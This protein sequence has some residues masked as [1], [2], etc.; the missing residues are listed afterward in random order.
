MPVRIARKER[1]KGTLTLES[2]NTE[3]DIINLEDQS[4]DYIIEGQIDLSNMAEGDEVIIRTYIAVDGTNQR[5][6]DE[7]K[8]TG[9]QT[10]PIVRIP[11][12]TCSYDAKFRV[13]ITQTAGTPRS[14]PYLF[15]LQVME[16]I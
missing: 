13:T 9:S 4:D 3:T 5:K 15:I 1:Y 14:F 12:I 2:L 8:F 7:L 6:T 11:A 16:V 10:I